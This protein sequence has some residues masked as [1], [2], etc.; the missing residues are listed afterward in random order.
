[1]A[2]ELTQETGRRITTVIE[3]IRET[4]LLSQRLSM[5]LQRGNAVSFHNTMVTE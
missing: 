4:T 3:D 1:M 2:K 5:A